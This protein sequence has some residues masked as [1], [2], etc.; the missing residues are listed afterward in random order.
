MQL[1]LANVHSRAPPMSKLVLKAGANREAGITELRCTDTCLK[2]DNNTGLRIVR[3]KLSG[4][5]ISICRGHCHR[6]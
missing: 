6:L 1:M 3:H 5:Y 2:L 4:I